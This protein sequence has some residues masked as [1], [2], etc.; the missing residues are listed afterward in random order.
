MSTIAAERFDRFSILLHWLTA[1]LV[2]GLWGMGHTWNMFDRATG[3]PG[4][5][6][7]LHVSFGGLLAL[8]L[9]V[10]LLWRA[11]HAAP[12]DE[13]PGSLMTRAAHGVHLLLY[14]LLIAEVVL[15]FL[16]RWAGGRPV[17]LFGM[18]D[19]PALMD[20]GTGWRRTLFGWHA[21]AANGIMIVAG[22][23]AAAA[24][25]HHYVLRD[26]VLRRMLP[27]PRRTL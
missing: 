2:A 10:R 8:V 9:M 26:N 23:H 17:S 21:L 18:M 5:M 27:A 22:L 6:K 3:I 25:L 11:T 19:I 14:A 20:L 7:S 16:L 13:A 24:L 1:L 15:G 12:A 4:V